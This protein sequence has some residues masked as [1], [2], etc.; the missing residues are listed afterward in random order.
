MVP[1]GNISNYLYLC[2]MHFNHFVSYMSM[3]ILHIIIYTIKFKCSH[4]HFI[5]ISFPFLTHYCSEALFLNKPQVCL[6][7]QN[8][9]CL[10]KIQIAALD[11]TKF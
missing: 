2:T 7:I 3:D 5:L 11:L 10:E 4:T 6:Y 1:S 9:S 8:P